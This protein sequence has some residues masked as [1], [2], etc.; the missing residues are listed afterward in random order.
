MD[1]SLGHINDQQKTVT[2]W[3][4]MDPNKARTQQESADEAPSDSI[5]ENTVWDGIAEQVPF[6]SG[7]D[8]EKHSDLD[9]G[10]K[11]AL[12]VVLL[13]AAIGVYGDISNN[14]EIIHD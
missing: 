1:E 11:S 13:R 4:N 3:E 6:N 14:S 8:S 9:E 7:T 12:R 2:G 10:T 5:V